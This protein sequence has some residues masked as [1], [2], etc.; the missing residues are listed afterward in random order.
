MDFSFSY[1]SW[2]GIERFLKQYNRIKLKFVNDYSGRVKKGY[3]GARKNVETPRWLELKNT[4]PF[5]S[6]LS[7][8]GFGD[9][10]QM[11][12]KDTESGLMILEDSSVVLRKLL[13]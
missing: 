5:P 3:D 12:G 7:R 4:K 9:S 13:H 2:E 10:F 1:Y 8:K 6:G 11:F